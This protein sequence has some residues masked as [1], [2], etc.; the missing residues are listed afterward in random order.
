MGSL[1]RFFAY[2]WLALYISLQVRDV[3]AHVP[4]ARNCFPFGSAH[5]EGLERPHESRDDWWCPQDEQYGFMGYASG[6]SNILSEVM[7]EST[8]QNTL[9]DS[10]ILLRWLIAMILVICFQRSMTTFNE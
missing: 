2:S 4:V 7:W 9:L 10:A 1:L 6:S 8:D 5:L 3:Q